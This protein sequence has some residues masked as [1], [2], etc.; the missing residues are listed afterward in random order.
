MLSEK[1]EHYKKTGKMLTVTPARY[2]DDYPYLRE[3]D[4]LAL[5]NEQ[6]NL[7]NAYKNFFSRK[8]VGEP[9]FKAKHRDKDSYTTNL[10]NGNREIGDSWIKLPKIGRIPARIQD[11]S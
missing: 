2:K 11:A 3:V 10:V 9:K 8:D 6:M 7:E 4:S 5:A 1:K